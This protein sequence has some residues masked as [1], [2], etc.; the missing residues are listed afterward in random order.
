MFILNAAFRI[1]VR[2]TLNHNHAGFTPPTSPTLADWAGFS[3][4]QSAGKKQPEVFI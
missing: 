1:N 2:K 4:V 3:S